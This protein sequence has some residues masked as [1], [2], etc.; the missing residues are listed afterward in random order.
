M[1]TP[2]TPVV[3]VHGLWLHASS[4]GP[5]IDRFREAGYDPVA[6]GWPGERETVEDA[7]NQPD[8]VARNGV[9]EVVA[10]FLEVIG[11]LARKPIAVRHSF[12]GLVVQ[13]LLAEGHV[14]AAVA[15]DPAPVKGVLALPPSAIRVASVA[16]R[17][18]ANRGRAVALSRKQFRY[19]FCNAVPEPES[20]QLYDRWTIPSPGRPL[21]EAAVANF[22]PGSPLKV[23]TKRDDRGPLL[24]TTGGKDHAVPPA[25]SRGALKLYRKSGAVTDHHEFPDRGHSLGVDSGWSE[26]AEVALG[27]L[28]KQSV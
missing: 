3:F 7:R 8:A 25:M 27:W 24:I 22:M 14:S 15:L 1:A 16:L 28:E 2:G 17:N 5:W 12:G 19:A 11:G 9:G 13:R 23:D 6:P 26:V 4:W 20:D 21:F 18:P 10:H